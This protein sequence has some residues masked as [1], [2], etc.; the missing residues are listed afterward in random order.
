MTL[1]IISAPTFET[2][3]IS[4]KD[5]VKFRPFTVREEKIF[6]IAQESNDPKDTANAV[7]QV[8]TNCLG[9][10]S[11]DVNKLPIFD[12]EYLFLQIRAKS[13][14]DVVTLRYRD[15][16]D[17]KIY[18]FDVDIDSIKPT[19]F[20][21]HH[22]LIDIGNDIKIQFRYPTINDTSVKTKIDMIASCLETI[23]EGDKVYDAASYSLEEKQ[24]FINNFGKVNYEKILDE[25]V[26][27]M[28]KLRHTIKYTNTKKNDRIIELEGIADFFPWG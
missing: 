18:S 8:L 1:P 12:V 3:L 13:V 2:S 10:S 28:P 22:T 19:I 11:I 16:E 27:T 17:N 23:Y 4:V 24:E 15:K 21:E 20:P 25:F 26:D 7:K 6:L 9:D 14:N 5:K